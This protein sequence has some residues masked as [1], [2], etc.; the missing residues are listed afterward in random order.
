[1]S[2][3]CDIKVVALYAVELSGG[4]SM[5]PLFS[6]IDRWNLVEP[7]YD[8]TRKNSVVC[9]LL[10]QI[11]NPPSVKVPALFAIYTALFSHV[12]KPDRI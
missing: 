3:N 2:D 9:D 1:M 5:S 4:S 11:K 12:V 10:S 7:R 8:E 6:S